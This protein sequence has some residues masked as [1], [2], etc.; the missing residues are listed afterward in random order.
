MKEPNSIKV[1]GWDGKVIDGRRDWEERQRGRGPALVD[2]V[3]R[4]GYMAKGRRDMERG[5]KDRGEDARILWP[6]ICS[7]VMVIRHSTSLNS[8]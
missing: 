4:A 1:S 5:G 8:W 3:D 7:L 6:P 2:G